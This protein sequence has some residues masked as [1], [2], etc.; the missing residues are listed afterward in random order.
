MAGTT[1]TYEL[2][3]HVTTNPTVERTG[4]VVLIPPGGKFKPGEFAT[5]SVSLPIQ[6]QPVTT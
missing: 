4:T 2:V 3:P 1:A 5:F 6:G